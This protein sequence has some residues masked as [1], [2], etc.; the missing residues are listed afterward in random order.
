MYR[1][2]EKTSQFPDVVD[3]GAEGVHLARLVLQLRNVLAQRREAVV[4]LIW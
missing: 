2:P 3:S 1:L 4:D